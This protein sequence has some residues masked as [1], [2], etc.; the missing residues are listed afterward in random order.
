MRRPLW[1]GRKLFPAGAGGKD[2]ARTGL[3]SFA[4]TT[5]AAAGGSLI[6]NPQLRTGK[7]VR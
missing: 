2:A 3:A 5:T 7:V 6:P 4:L 1:P